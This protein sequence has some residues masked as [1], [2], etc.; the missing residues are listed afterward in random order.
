MEIPN[1]S[2]QSLYK[3]FL[4]IGRVR[5]AEQLAKRFPSLKEESVMEP[6]KE[7]VKPSNKVPEAKPKG[8]NHGKVR[9]R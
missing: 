2:I 3:H 5:H 8:V 9:K 4:A 6:E 7:A 1:S